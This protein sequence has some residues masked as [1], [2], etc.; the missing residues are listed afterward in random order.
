M[1]LTTLLVVCILAMCW[2]AYSG[3]KVCQ[4]TEKLL[5]AVEYYTFRLLAFIVAVC[6]VM[7]GVT[8]G[9]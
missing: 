7:I 2:M 5:D 4:R 6:L 9:S 3:S 8:Y 1:I